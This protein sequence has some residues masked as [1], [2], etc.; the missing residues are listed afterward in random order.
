MATQILSGYL[1]TVQIILT[2]ESVGLLTDMAIQRRAPSREKL[3]D[4]GFRTVAWPYLLA[5]GV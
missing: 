2:L 3:R 4:V 1:L 5:K